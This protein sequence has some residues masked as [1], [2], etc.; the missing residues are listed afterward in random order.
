MV[1]QVVQ[2]G[3]VA[4]VCTQE[5]YAVLDVGGVDGNMGGEGKPA[6][7]CGHQAMSRKWTLSKSGRSI[8]R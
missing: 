4:A 6:Y 5:N 7:G 2:D 1:P 3:N 8:L